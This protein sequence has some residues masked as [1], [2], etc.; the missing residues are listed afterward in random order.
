MKTILFLIALFCTVFGIM[1]I[2]LTIVNTVI[3]KKKEQN[4]FFE[5][6]IFIIA[7][8]AWTALFHLSNQ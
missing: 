7:I 4:F 6:I 2:I 3:N 5:A 8:I 1:F